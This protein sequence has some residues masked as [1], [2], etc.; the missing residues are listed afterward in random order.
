MTFFDGPG[1][2]AEKSVPWP[3]GLRPT[4]LVAATYFGAGPPSGVVGN[5][6]PASILLVRHGETEWNRLG[7]CQG[8]ADEPLNEAGKAQA[9]EVADRLRSEPVAA[10]VSSPLKRAH[11]TALEIARHHRLSVLTHEGLREINHGRLEGVPFDRLDDHVPGIRHAWRTAPHTV[12]MPEGE[13]LADLHARASSAFTTHAAAYLERHRNGGPYGRLVVV[14][15]A[16][17]IGAILC[18]VQGKDLSAV[19]QYRLLPCGYWRLDHQGGGW[20]VAASH[21]LLPESQ[22]RI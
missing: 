21:G 9:K 19:R 6:R 13:T 16:V 8:W 14:A 4:A 10:V 22:A 2:H 5:P 7:I 20:T 11:Q 1:K 15:H 3:P 18:G 17:T 12:S